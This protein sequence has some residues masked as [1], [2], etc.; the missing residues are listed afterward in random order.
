MADFHA[1]R[2]SLITA[3]VKSGCSVRVAQQLARHSDPRLTL[4][5]YT[6]IGVHDL[7]AG[8]NAMPSIAP[9]VH[10][11]TGAEPGGFQR[12]RAQRNRCQARDTC[13]EKRR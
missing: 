4:G 11:A 8:L 7:S 13:G 1:L 9:A 10:Y 3:L 12:K 5:V 2:V 6:N